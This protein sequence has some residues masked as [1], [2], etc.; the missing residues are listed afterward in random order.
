[1][2]PVIDLSLSLSGLFAV[3]GPWAEVWLILLLVG[4][5]G[6]GVVI[7]ALYPLRNFLGRFW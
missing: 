1:M 7:V 2:K 6:V 3:F 5:V 4:F